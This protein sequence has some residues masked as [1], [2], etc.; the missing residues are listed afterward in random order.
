MPVIVHEKVPLREGSQHRVLARVIAWLALSSWLGVHTRSFLFKN[1][2]RLQART[3]PYPTLCTKSKTSA[4]LPSFLWLCWP[5]LIYL[6]QFPGPQ[7]NTVSGACVLQ[8]SPTSLAQPQNL[9]SAL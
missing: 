1:I 7:E 2:I 4:W 8:V 3:S 5:G 6:D 9:L